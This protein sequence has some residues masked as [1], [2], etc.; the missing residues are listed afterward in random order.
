V[1]QLLGYHM[2]NF[3]PALVFLAL[4]YSSWLKNRDRITTIFMI[5]L[6]SGG[7]I[8][9]QHLLD[10][11]LPPAPLS[12]VEGMV[13][14]QLPVLM[15]GLV[16]VAWH[17]KL[18]TMVLYNVAL[19]VFELTIVIALDQMQGDR[20]YVFCF[21][22]LIRMVCFLV[23]GI[24]IN[25]LIN[26][27]RTQQEALK[28]ANQQLSHY[29]STLETLTVSRERNRM[30]RELHDTVVHTL[31]GLAVQLETT[32][33]YLD[34]D[35]N[36]TRHLVDQSL[37]SARS[38]LQETRRVLKALRASPLEDLGFDLALKQM[39]ASA[40]ERGRFILE[41]SL[42]EPC[43]LM[44]PDIEQCLYRVAQE[45]V[46]NVVHHANAQHLCLQLSANE[47]E[48]LLIIQDDGMGFSPQ[49]DISPGHFGIAGMKER[50]DLSGGE[51]V[52][53]SKP[54]SGTTIRLEIKGYRQ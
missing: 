16:V 15:I 12:N 42:P 13:L 18:V 22:V 44:S 47:Q 9:V 25:Q 7:P 52:I 29:A 46:E 40:A 20:L 39:L 17:S 50:A 3:V 41:V 11:K 6:I 43:P 21:I 35:P 4:S 33:A 53:K 30:S 48:L 24:F 45:A 19:S 10:L 49:G 36:T 23:V 32:K 28:T 54:G 27:L 26:D 5:L 38:G 51:L 14:R 34:F 37:E 31:S 2:L 8:L 1:S